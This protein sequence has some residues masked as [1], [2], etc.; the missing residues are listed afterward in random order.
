MSNISSGEANDFLYSIKN[1]I[2]K[3]FK[4]KM[5]TLVQVALATVISASESE[6]VTVRLSS[7]PADGSQDFLVRNHTGE[8]LVPGDSVWI[9]Y[10]D[11]LTNAYIAIRNWG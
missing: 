3:I 5:K 1:F 6:E 2:E 9:H 7:S 10:W 4:K 11:T 8:A